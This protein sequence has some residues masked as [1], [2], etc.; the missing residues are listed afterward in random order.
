[1][2][3]EWLVPKDNEFYN[4]FEEQAKLVVIASEK[5]SEILENYS[6]E[7]TEIYANEMK[8]IEHKADEIAAKIYIKTA[9]SFMTPIDTERI[10]GLNKELDN[11][12]DMIEKFISMCNVYELTGID[13]YTL[14]LGNLLKDTSVII[15]KNV[16]YLR[17]AEKNK[18]NIS[19]LNENIRAKER[20]GDE[21]FKAAMKE[22]FKSNDAIHIIKMRDVYDTLEDAMDACREVADEISDIITKLA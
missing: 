14:K 10:I 9:T 2:V 16:S 20:E 11:I 15:Q 8:D 12:V 6:P 17:D 13:N 19:A 7:K 4:F 21:I 1:M 22:L 18:E 3:F 5:L